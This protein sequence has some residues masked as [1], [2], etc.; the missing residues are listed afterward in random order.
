VGKA[1]GG[2]TS[3]ISNSSKQQSFL[4]QENSQVVKYGS[5]ENNSAKKTSLGNRKSVGQILAQGLKTNSSMSQ[6]K[7]LFSNN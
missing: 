4:L 6:Q 7:L 3:H 1:L 5:K 2:R